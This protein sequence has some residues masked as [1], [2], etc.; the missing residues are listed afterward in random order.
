MD[1]IHELLDKQLIDRRG[2]NMGRVDGLVAEIRD[3]RPPRVCWMEQGSVTLVRR[4][5]PALARAWQRIAGWLGL[6]LA[7]SRLSLETIRD[8]GVDVELDVDAERDRSL[9]RGEKWIRRHIVN[10]IPGGSAAK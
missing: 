10:R 3:G 5:H 4:L 2:R 8:I 6:R 1:L 7:G 9:L